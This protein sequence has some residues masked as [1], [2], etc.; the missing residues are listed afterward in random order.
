MNRAKLHNAFYSLAAMVAL[1]VLA[2]G[3]ATAE[4]IAQYFQT[5]G[6]DQWSI[7]TSGITTTITAS[8]SVFF[9]YDLG[10]TPFSGPELATF[11]L[12]AT[13]D[14]IG[15][16]ATNCSNG[17]DFTQAGYSG[18]FS[19]TDI[20]SVDPGSDLLSGVFTVASTGATLATAI[21]SAGSRA[22]VTPA[23]SAV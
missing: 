9:L 15:N 21:G 19:F 1:G 8:G 14:T 22:L 7:S 12:T 11:S 17:D 18:S 6:A 4:Q 23:L 20:G 2:P 13:S 5:G 3:S 16:C 10:G